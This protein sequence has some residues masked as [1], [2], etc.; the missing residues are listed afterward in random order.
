MRLIR[1]AS[2]VSPSAAG[3]RQDGGLRGQL[4]VV[5]G[6][7]VVAPPQARSSGTRAG[8]PSAE[9]SRISREPARSLFSP[10]R[11]G[12]HALARQDERYEDSLARPLV[13]RE[14]LAVA[15]VDEFSILFIGL[16]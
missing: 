2:R 9:G 15:T 16:Q 13:G 10:Q 3:F 14:A 7:L 1:L 12:F 6:V 11:S 8:W 5:A 4:V